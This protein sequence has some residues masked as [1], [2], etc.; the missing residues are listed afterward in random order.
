MKRLLYLLLVAGLA[1]LP[2]SRLS[3]QEPPRYH[4]DIKPFFAKYCIECHNADKLKGG[5]NL[6][7]Y[8]SLG[9]GDENGPVLVPHKPDSSR[10]VL[11]VE[12]R[13]APAMPPLKARQPKPHEKT[14]LRAWVALGA[15]EDAPTKL[16]LPDIK[17]RLSI[18]APVAALAY[19]PD[20][21]M[22]A[23]AAGAEVT[24][25]DPASGESA[26]TLT[27]DAGPVSALAFSSD[28]KWLAVASGASGRPAELALYSISSSGPHAV[29]LLRRIHAHRDLIFG[30]SFSPD[31]KTIVTCSYDRLVK[32][33]DVASGKERHVLKDHS[34]AVYAVAFSPDGKLMASASAD[35]AIKGRGRR[36]Q[37]GPRLGSQSLRGQ[38]GAVDLRSRGTD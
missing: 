19:R 4:R 8:Q 36:G 2:S 34:D 24:L 13:A 27:G 29:A 5:L 37:D 35:R 9:E 25:V 26:G 10:I 31:G 7:S 28:G 1:A 30:V 18:S 32:L 14:L 21:K 38:T 33:W 12:G 15:S 22:L 11:V 17:P 6:E 23:A 16:E 3:A 20:G